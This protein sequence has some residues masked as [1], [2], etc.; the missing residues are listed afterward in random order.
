MA[1]RPKPKTRVATR[2][3]RQ[4]LV[5]IILLACS[6]ADAENWPGWR[7]PRGDGSSNDASVP[8][9][10]NGTTNENI[11]WRA[12]TLG[13]GHSSPVI[14][15]ERIFLTACETDSQERLLLCLDRKTGKALWQQTV[16]AGAL[17]TIHSLNS[18]ASGTPAT[19]GQTL[20]VAFMRTD[21]TKIPA[22]NVGSARDITSGEMVVAA[23]DLDGNRKWLVTPGEFISAHGFCTC[24]VIY[25][26]LVIVN[27]DHDGQSYVVALDKQTGEQR[28]RVKR[29]YG[30]RSYV[31]PLIREIDG[32]T[33]MVFSGSKRIVSMNPDDGSLHWSIEGPTEQFVASMVYDGRLFYMACGFPDY[34]VLGVRPDGEGDVTQTSVAWQTKSARCYVPSPVVL[35]GYLVVADDRGTANCFDAATGERHWQARFGKGFHASLVHAGGLVYLIAKDGETTVLRPGT[36]PEVVA[37]NPLGEYVSASPA[38]SDGHLFIRG[39]ESLFCI[40]GTAKSELIR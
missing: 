30:I 27:G 5:L 35:D 11:V 1:T 37:R 40:G 2:M 21:G 39:E 26:D 31:T 7:G 4:C 19:D 9:R 12:S 3:R 6:A 32:R 16:F 38:I 23:Y 29:E 18:R 17:E 36:E 24:P 22:P 13:R 20:F 8:I 10:W 14:W 25:Q 28:W 33:Q 15:N 34:F